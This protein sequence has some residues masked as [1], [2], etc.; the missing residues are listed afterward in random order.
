MSVD[1]KISYDSPKSGVIKDPTFTVYR[2]GGPVEDK[3]KPNNI[4]NF[5]IKPGMPLYRS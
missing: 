5:P 4:I 3:P 1:K 2:K